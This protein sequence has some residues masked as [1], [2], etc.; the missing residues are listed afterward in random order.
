MTRRVASIGGRVLPLVVLGALAACGGGNRVA[1]D[2]IERFPQAEIKRPSP[3]SFQVVD[4]TLGG[5]AK[6]AIQAASVSRL[7]WKVDVPAGAWLEFSIGLREDAWT[8][9]GD[10]V[11]FLVGVSDGQTFDELMSLVVNPYANAGDRGWHPLLLDLGK[12]SGRQ[13]EIVFNTRSS[14]DRQP[15]DDRG[16][17]PVWGEPRVV[18]R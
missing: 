1:V 14:P 3:E 17:L 16:D 9:E 12:Y 7:G 2:L 8:V 18:V 10:G 15:V 6:R 5:T 4:A 13:V 11:L